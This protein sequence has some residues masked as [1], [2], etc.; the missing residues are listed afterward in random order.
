[1]FAAMPGIPICIKSV[2]NYKIMQSYY[3]DD[4]V[5]GWVISDFNNVLS[6]KL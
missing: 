3:I 1:M 6:N 5:F 4:P 2:D